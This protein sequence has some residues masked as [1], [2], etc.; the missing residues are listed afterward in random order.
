[1]Y[2]SKGKIK[3]VCVSY[4][5]S[6]Y[7]KLFKRPLVAKFHYASHYVGGL[8][9]ESIQTSL[10]VGRWGIAALW[11]LAMPSIPTE[12]FKNNP[13][14]TDKLRQIACRTQCNLKYLHESESQHQGLTSCHYYQVLLFLDLK[15]YCVHS[16][17]YI[18]FI[19]F[20]KKGGNA[21]TINT[22]TF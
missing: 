9:L 1:M 12:Q 18:R 6:N 11:F 3:L 20:S 7:L 22:S 10:N 15:Y 19:S 16:C 8:Q 17:K 14:T 21:E 4:S 2:N 5:G 13:F